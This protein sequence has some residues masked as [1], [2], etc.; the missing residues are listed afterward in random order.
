MVDNILKVNLNGLELQNPIMTASGT[1]GY[2]NEYDDYNNVL[3]NSFIRKLMKIQYH[4]LKD[5]HNTENNY[6]F[7]FYLSK[8]KQVLPNT[9][10]YINFKNTLIN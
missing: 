9:D 10:E 6:L 4:T 7:I 2:A 8:C 1:Y 5:G 3:N